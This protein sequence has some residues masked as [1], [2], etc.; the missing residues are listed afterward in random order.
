M[1]MSFTPITD[2]FAVAPQIVPADVAAIAEAGFKSILCNRPD[3][4][5]SDQPAYAAIERAA[6]AAGLQIRYLPGVSG[7]I[8]EDDGRAMQQALAELPEPVLAYC[9]SGARSASLWQL[10]QSLD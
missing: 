3:D 2:R 6:L 8:T 7:R 10:A 9:R 1:R 5:A 4:E